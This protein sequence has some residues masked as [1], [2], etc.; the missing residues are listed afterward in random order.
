MLLLLLSQED[1]CI[2]INSTVALN[3]WQW[4]PVKGANKQKEYGKTGKNP[5]SAFSDLASRHV[6]TTGARLASYTWIQLNMSF[7]RE[8]NALLPASSHQNMA[9]CSRAEPERTGLET[10]R[11]VLHRERER[12]LS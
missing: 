7:T 1:R 11:T 2:T 5:K 8:K 3:N 4:S 6:V 10:K 12:E 9:A